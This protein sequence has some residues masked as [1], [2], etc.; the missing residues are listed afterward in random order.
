M[1]TLTPKQI[2]AAFKYRKSCR[3]YDPERKISQEDFNFILELGRL[4]PSSVGSEPWQFLVIQ[5]PELRQA[6]KPF[7]WGM[8]NALDTA[9]H[10]VVILAKKNARY[11][12]EFLRES[13]VRR[14]VTDPEQIAATL[15][16]YRNFQQ[17]DIDILNSERS[18]FDWACR[19]TYIA[20]ANMMTG[21]AMAGIDSCPIEGFNY[22]AMNRLLAGQ[23]LFDPAEWGVSVAVT[24]GYRT[25]DIADKNRKA[26]EEVVVWAE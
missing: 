8:L 14:G 12:S 20:L 5:N 18:L 25:R 23:G 2:L 19:Q 9:S 22:E 13:M 26:A 21:A 11:D 6:M 7:A 15:E 1:T 16:K 3:H 17:T 4:S 24:F 10:I